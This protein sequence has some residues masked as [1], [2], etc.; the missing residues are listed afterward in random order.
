MGRWLAVLLWGLGASAWAQAPGRFTKLGDEVVTQV[1]ERFFDAKKAT[2]WA[3]RHRAYAA[4]AKSE[5]D[6]ARLT[7]QALADLQTSH[8]AYYARD[9]L[10]YV[11]LSTV[12]RWAR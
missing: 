9:T 12:F 7:Q 4:S 5:E 11:G 6:F 1:R 8:T 10:G 3:G 2:E